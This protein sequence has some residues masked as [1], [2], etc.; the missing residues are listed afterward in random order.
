ML[1]SISAAFGLELSSGFLSTL[2]AAM[3]GSTG[4]TFAGRALAA[5]LLKFIPGGGTIAGGLISGTTAAA[6]AIALG[7]IY[8]ATLV[9]LF[10]KSDGELPDPEAIAR[11]FKRR[12]ALGDSDS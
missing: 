3:I 10:S 7:E 5:N 12:L 9:T 8:L 11:E 6:L 2:V 4:A 1:A